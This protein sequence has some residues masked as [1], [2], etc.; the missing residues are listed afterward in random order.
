M[1]SSV[2]RTIVSICLV[3]LGLAGG[4]AT[5]SAS[6]PTSEHF[7]ATTNETVASVSCSAGICTL[8][9]VGTG[10]A[11]ELGQVSDDSIITLNFTGGPPCATASVIETLTG[12]NGSVTVQE[13]GED[14]SPGN[15]S[16]TP[17]P[18]DM[19]SGTWVLSAATG[20]FAGAT[21]SG[22]FAAH[23]G[24]PTTINT[25]SGDISV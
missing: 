13:A 17:A 21:G 10:T 25:V 3:A 18:V 15:T 14:C 16:Q 11:T 8:V 7:Q 2:S 6:A 24:G 5:A 23:T 12:S 19:A 1:H 4:V 20:V 22:R 9:A